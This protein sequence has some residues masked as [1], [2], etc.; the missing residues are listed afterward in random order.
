M[1]FMIRPVLAVVL[2]ATSSVCLSQAMVRFDIVMKKF[3]TA[4]QADPDFTQ[5][6]QDNLARAIESNSDYRVVSGGAAHYYLRGRAMSDGKRDILTLQLF[7]AK[8]DRIVWVQNYDYRKVNAGTMA[9]DVL[10][11]LSFVPN[12]DT[13]N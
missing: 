10:D 4:G 12:D 13:W 11:A 2:L 1:N 7:R 6:L 9:N 5:I 8:T 3:E